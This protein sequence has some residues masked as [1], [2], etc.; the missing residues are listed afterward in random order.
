[1]NPF[2]PLSYY[3][4]HKGR[5]L[6]LTALVTLST[7]GICVMVRLL[8]S[9]AEQ[10]EATESYLTRVSL[11]FARAGSLEPGVGARV[12][13]HPD[14]ARTIPTRSL[15]LTVPMFGALPSDYPLF[16]IPEGDLSALME[17]CDLELTAG[18]LPQARSNELALTEE[19]AQALGLQVGAVVDRSLDEAAFG[20]ISRPMLLVGVLEAARDPASRTKVLLGLASL[21]YLESHEAYSHLPPELLVLPRPGRRATVEQFLEA[22]IAS[23]RT[24]VWTRQRVA[25]SV[26]K[27]LRTF[28]LIFGVVDLLV[29]AVMALVVGAINRIAMIQRI[30]DLGLLH[31]LGH[32]KGWLVRRLAQEVTVIAGLGWLA[33]LV[34]SWLIF[35]WL[36]EQVY[37]SAGGLHLANLTPIWFTVPI[38]LVAVAFVTLSARRT[39]ARLDAVAIVDRGTVAAEA[40]DLRGPPFRAPRS[41]LRPLSSWTFYWRHRRRGLALAATIALMIL[42]VVFPVFLLSPMIDVNKLLYE[43]L[44]H[45]TVLSPRES[46]T[47]DPGVVAQVRL[48]PGVARVVPAIRLGLLIDVPPLNRNNVTLFAV[49]EADL[50]HLLDLYGLHVKEGRLPEP[51]SNEIV[52]TRVI[53]TNRGLGLG[54]H[55]GRPAYEYDYDMPTEMV[56]VG[57]LERHNPGN[58]DLWL[59]F[60]PYE[61]VSSHELYAA[62]SVDLLLVPEEEHREEVDAWLEEAVAS[63][64]VA[65][66]TY[67]Q[68]LLMHRQDMQMLLLL[69][70][71]V[72]GIVAIVAAIALAILSYIFFAQRREEFGILAALGHSRRWLVLRTVGETVAVVA[73][74]WLLGAAI[75]LA[76]LAAMQIGLFAP[77]GMALD[78]TSPTPWLSTMPLPLIIIGVSA[79]L[80]VWMLSRLDPVSI[81]EGRS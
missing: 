43:Y 22:T 5:A 30:R 47:V 11:V 28:H 39:L 55:V 78:L 9:T 35:W 25:E 26:S 44:Y 16:G 33:G 53:A 1:M 75:C 69:V 23:P 4:R 81:I 32:G 41:S 56:V 19:L 63:E 50:Q 15:W 6:L 51:R 10:Y 17:V 49:S 3:R 38:P 67:E 76:G 70:T 7:L 29:A 79:G 64:R 8:D 73:V 74:A 59:G 2:S 68:L 52:L 77:K 72:E 65:V 71:V 24:E 80:V 60:A 40:D 14:V 21:E 13:T 42:G 37:T 27:A 54:D 61:Y 57:I 12:Q 62:R 58:R 48:H 31:A 66:R 36:K 45:V 46:A 18:R 20:S 34:L